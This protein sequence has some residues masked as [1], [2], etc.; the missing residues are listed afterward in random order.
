MES[1]RLHVNQSIEDETATTNFKTCS[2]SFESHFSALF[3]DP[4]GWKISALHNIADKAM[5]GCGMDLVF[6]F[7][8][9]G[10]FFTGAWAA[11]STWTSACAQENVSFFVE[12]LAN[13]FEILEVAK[14]M[15]TE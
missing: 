4:Q 3:D 14:Y 9:I 10:P 5:D 11:L 12:N 13:S 15:I 8:G 7:G 6:F 2:D 1:S